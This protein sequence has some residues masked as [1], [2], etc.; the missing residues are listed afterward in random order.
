[1]I[2]LRP[3]SL[4]EAV[5][6]L[7]D[8]PSLVPTAGC[9]D[10][11]VRGPEALHQ[12]SRVIAALKRAGLVKRVDAGWIVP[13]DDAEGLAKSIARLVHDGGA[14]ELTRKSERALAFAKLHTFESTFER[15]IEHFRELARLEGEGAGQQSPLVLHQ[16]AHPRHHAHQVEEHQGTRVQ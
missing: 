8:D 3:S 10:L 7:A 13:I 5:R 6:F 12:M 11:M 2:A 9:T 14:D 4:D 15:R 1:M 16:E